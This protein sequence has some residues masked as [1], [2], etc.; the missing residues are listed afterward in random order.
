MQGTQQRVGVP[1]F[2]DFAA[3]RCVWVTHE[4]QAAIHQGRA[5]QITAWDSAS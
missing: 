5:A 3:V 1:I 2:I 4:V